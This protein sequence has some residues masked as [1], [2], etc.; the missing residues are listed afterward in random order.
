MSEG[1]GYSAK[2]SEEDRQ[3][4]LQYLRNLPLENLSSLNGKEFKDQAIR[5]ADLAANSND[6]DGKSF[7]RCRLDGPA[8]VGF[9]GCRF[10][11]GMFFQGADERST[12]L[13]P[14]DTDMLGIIGF[15]GC[16]FVSSFFTRTNY[17]GDH[18]FLA[19]FL[20]QFDNV[21][22]E[23]QLNT[24][25]HELIREI[26]G[27]IRARL[28]YL[29]LGSALCL[30]DICAA[31]EDANGE[32]N[33]P[34]FRTWYRRWVVGS[35]SYSL[36]AEECYHYRC[37]YL[38]QH[39]TQ[40]SK[41]RYK[42]ILFLEPGGP[43][44]SHRCTYHEA[45]GV[46]LGLDIPELCDEIIGGVMNWWDAKKD[47]PVVQQNLNEAMRLHPAGWRKISGVGVIT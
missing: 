6:I 20:G 1:T 40:H 10:E 46:I 22:K 28:Y 3:K 13:I 19:G 26:H 8:V 37:A 21:R 42:R 47:D 41:S 45:D 25:L 43:V 33:G 14:G 23:S 4:R 29:A 27:A 24:G 9:A 32:T 11:G 16:K 7:V 12:L 18:K 39:R 35:G 2:E 34:K 36:E 15:R 38:H 5:I 17:V 31:L 30:P 44:T